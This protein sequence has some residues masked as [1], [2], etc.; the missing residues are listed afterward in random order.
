MCVC[1]CARARRAPVAGARRGPL[2][3]HRSPPRDTTDKCDLGTAA[4][5]MRDA[6][7][8]VPERGGRR[9]DAGS[10]TKDAPATRL[11]P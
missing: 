2:G 7:A 5:S 6:R 10:R 4:G 1:V 11:S 8:L 3:T 9:E